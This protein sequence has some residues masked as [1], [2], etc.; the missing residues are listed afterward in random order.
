MYEYLHTN[1]SEINLENLLRE[2]LENVLREKFKIFIKLIR[3]AIYIN[4][5]AN[6]RES[7]VSQTK[8]IINYED[9]VRI[10]RIS[11]DIIYKTS[12]LP[13]N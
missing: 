9:I 7:R 13:S 4:I 6:T 11:W 10:P 12:A 5:R 2:N 1:D 8:W 3:R